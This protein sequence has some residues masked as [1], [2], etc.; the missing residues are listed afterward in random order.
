M[1]AW[2]DE[3]HVVMAPVGTGGCRARKSLP[4]V[5]ECKRRS[6][7]RTRVSSPMVS[8]EIAIADRAI[9]QNR[10]GSADGKDYA[11]WREPIAEMNPNVRSPYGIRDLLLTS[12]TTGT[13]QGAMR[14]HA[15]FLILLDGQRERLD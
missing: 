7:R 4:I 5:A 13:T 15:N 9:N 3:G 2:G 12:A 10:S 1:L 14:S 8:T 11:A 6:V